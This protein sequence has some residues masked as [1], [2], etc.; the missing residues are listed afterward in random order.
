MQAV[1]EL[2]DEFHDKGWRRFNSEKRCAVAYARIQSRR[3]LVAHFQNSSLMH[4]DKR[5]RP[6]LINLGGDAP[7][8]EAF[9]PPRRSASGTAAVQRG[10]GRSTPGGSVGRPSR[11]STESPRAVT[12]AARLSPAATSQCEA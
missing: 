6:V 7:E 11:D 2:Y 4:E 1:R 10:A 9:P 12:L 5:C 8:A 3:A